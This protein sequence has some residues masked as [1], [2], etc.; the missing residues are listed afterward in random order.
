MFVKFAKYLGLVSNIRLI[1]LPLICITYFKKPGIANADV[2]FLL[3][4]DARSIESSGVS[5]WL[6]N[7]YPQMSQWADNFDR[8]LDQE[9][10][11]L[12]AM[13]LRE[14]DFTHFTIGLKAVYV[15]YLFDN[16]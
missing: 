16:R 8:D 10:E 5:R 9:D 12:N 3:S 13:G 2:D 6:E 1:C 4:I 7:K 11:I 15:V 14:N